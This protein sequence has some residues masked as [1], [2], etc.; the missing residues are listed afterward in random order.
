M[1]SDDLVIFELGEDFDPQ[2]S[3][4]YLAFIYKGEV[5][6][7]RKFESKIQSFRL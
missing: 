3:C 1:S 2:I 5:L 7:S 4:L 6:A